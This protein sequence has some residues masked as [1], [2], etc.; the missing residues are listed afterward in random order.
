MKK[1]QS[2]HDLHFF[3]SQAKRGK[4]PPGRTQT[5]ANGRKQG[6]MG[7][8]KRKRKNN[9]NE[10]RSTPH[11]QAAITGIRCRAGQGHL[12]LLWRHS[13]RFDTAQ[14]RSAPT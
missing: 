5:V 8:R 13:H 2:G 9:L 4:E 3:G 7:K 1:S 6:K 10:T 11:P 12:P 14:E